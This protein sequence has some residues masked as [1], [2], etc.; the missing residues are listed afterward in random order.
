[1]HW[2][3]DNTS[4]CFTNETKWNF[5][6][7]LFNIFYLFDNFHPDSVFTVSFF[8][9]SLAITYKLDTVT[10]CKQTEKK[11]GKSFTIMTH[12]KKI[13]VLLDKLSLAKLNELVKIKLNGK[14]IAHTSVISTGKKWI[15]FIRLIVTQLFDLIIVFIFFSCSKNVYY[16]HTR[17]RRNLMK[18]RLKIY[19]LSVGVFR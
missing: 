14:Y 6:G 12:K 1:M 5:Y 11:I 19:C 16:S 7:F 8:S 4:I 15:K 10:W 3:R 9:I 13:D 2:P 17:V 18:N